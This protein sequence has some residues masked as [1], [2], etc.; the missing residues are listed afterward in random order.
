MLRGHF[1]FDIWRIANMVFFRSRGYFMFVPLVK[2]DVPTKNNNNNNNKF[3]S[4]Q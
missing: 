3:E 1:T 2:L 4:T